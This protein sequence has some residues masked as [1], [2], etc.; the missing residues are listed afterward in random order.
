[1]VKIKSRARMDTQDFGYPIF[2]HFFYFFFFHFLFSFLSR[3]KRV[4]R[5][6]T[7][8]KESRGLLDT[9]LCRPYWIARLTNWCFGMYQTEKN[10]CC[11]FQQKTIKKKTNRIL[12]KKSRRTNLT[13]VLLLR[14]RLII[15]EILFLFG[16]FYIYTIYYI[17]ARLHTDKHKHAYTHTY[18]DTHLHGILRTVMGIKSPL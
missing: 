8:E 10:Y 4:H 9:R 2:Y 11:T 18:T 14:I 3:C 7:R 6:E 17:F 5:K 1:M 16:A 12:T 13:G 15:S